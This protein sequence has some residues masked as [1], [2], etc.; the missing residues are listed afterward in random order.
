MGKYYSDTK[1]AGYSGF[2]NS[3]RR[4]GWKTFLIVCC[5]TIFSIIVVAIG[6]IIGLSLYYTPERLS[7]IASKEASKYLDAKVKVY[8]LNYTF[9][10]TF[11]EL[12]VTIDSLKVVSN[13]LKNVSPDVRKQLPPD[14]DVLLTTGL[15]HA[16][17]NVRKL[18]KKKI[19]LSEIEIAAL[20]AN[21]VTVNDST[22]NFN[23]FPPMKKDME[24]PKMSLGKI[25][26]IEPIK[27]NFYD[28][29]KDIAIKADLDKFLLKQKKD[30]SFDIDFGIDVVG[31]MQQFALNDPIK[32]Q[33]GGEVDI[34]PKSMKVSARDLTLNLVPLS[35]KLNF[36]FDSEDGKYIIETFDMN[37]DIPDLLALKNYIPDDL[38]TLPKQLE[39]LK[40]YIPFEAEIAFS[41]PYVLPDSIPVNITPDMLPDLK[42]VLMTDGGNITYMPPIEKGV[43][44]ENLNFKGEIRLK[45]DNIEESYIN[46]S[47]LSLLSEGIHVMLNADVE[48]PFSEEMFVSGKLECDTRLEKSVS[49]LIASSG[50]S[51]KGGIKALT[52]FSFGLNNILNNINQPQIT[53]VDIGGDLFTKEIQFYEKK[54]GMTGS[55]KGLDFHFSLNTPLL[56]G[57]SLSS[58]EINLNLVNNLAVIKSKDL[59]SSIQGLKIK[60]DI[61]TEGIPANS[62]AGGEIN[63]EITG[64]DVNSPGTSVSL[65]GI[66]TELEGNLLKTP[67][68]FNGNCNTA[69]ANPD[70][71]ILME[72]IAHTPLYLVPNAPESLAAII[73]MADLTAHFKIDAG[74]FNTS[75]YLA[76]NLFSDVDIT[77]DLNNI[78]IKNLNARVDDS[79]LSL[80]GEIDG[81]APF[82][83][84]GSAS[85]LKTDLDVTFDNVDINRLAGAYYGAIEKQ[86]GKPYDFTMPPQGPYTA[87]DSLCVVIPRNLDGIIRL[88]S[89][90]AEYMGYKFS[91]LSTDIVLKDGDATLKRLTIGAP[92]C[93]VAVD[94]IYSTAA[95]NNIYMALNADIDDFDFTRFFE[96]FPQI[97]KTAPE[98]LNLTGSINAHANGTFGMFPSMFLD[99]NSM[100][101][102]FDVE[103]KN[104]LFARK[105][106]IEKFT[107][108]MMIKGDSPIKIE[109][110][111]INGSFHDNLLMLNPFHIEFDNYQIGI[112]GVNNL[113]G[114]M[115]YHLALEK[116]PFHMPFAVNLVGKFSHPDIRF[117]G[118]EVKD[119]REKE[120]SSVLSEKVDVNI[121]TNLHRGWIMFV[122]EAAK[123]DL[124]RKK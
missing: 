121:M 23:I 56:S 122:E 65:S 79:S 32:L 99:A 45:P 4:N 21:I 3:P 20:Y 70:E 50:L 10:S 123:Y 87:A 113:N 81:L 116:S 61:G 111:D 94:W 110:L 18:M 29:E 38:F 49:P 84:S 9:F 89:K 72:R 55:L 100:K 106:K 101:A 51:L 52:D 44:I 66:L 74:K 109:G 33:L 120:I 15:L 105:G 114:D 107:H 83:I 28:I 7:K 103:G 11:P 27:V 5:W 124:S 82:L 35:L 26:L 59:S 36:D 118:T 34:N 54:S 92:Y 31:R 71:A 17:V 57:N 12:Y 90:S 102:K 6:I 53:N 112:A 62:T 64:L 39:Y 95:L 68:S 119:G 30:G 2:G 46:I 76:T 88:R 58:G 60:A 16:G 22:N 41:S 97:T 77:T 73:S 75:S 85:V 108:L 117:G 40:G 63:I 80:S 47:E 37:L 14:A 115:Y 67:N 104:L 24:M 42:V 91:P 48:E 96:V 93:T 25:C 8:G 86:T 98:I 43:E 19:D 69:P 13:T 1:Y 78:E